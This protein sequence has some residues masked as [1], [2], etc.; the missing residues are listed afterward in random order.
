MVVS[1]TGEEDPPMA[2]LT[3][4][5]ELPQRVQSH[6]NAK[7]EDLATFAARAFDDALSL[8][9]DPLFQAELTEKT[10]RGIE[11]MKAG[12]VVDGLTAM[13]EIAAEKGIQ[14]NR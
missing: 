8:D 13:R 4:P 11:D 12:R 2:Q 1:K 7:G 6:L 9:D 3:I 10:R 5:D 14:F